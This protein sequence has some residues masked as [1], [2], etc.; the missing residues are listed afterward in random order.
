MEDGMHVSQNSLRVY[1]IKENIHHRGRSV[2]FGQWKVIS[3]AVNSFCSVQFR[4]DRKSDCPPARLP[5]RPLAAVVVQ[6]ARNDAFL[7]PFNGTPNHFR[8]L[9]TIQKKV[10]V[11]PVQGN[12]PFKNLVYCLRDWDWGCGRRV[13]GGV[14]GCEGRGVKITQK[15]YGV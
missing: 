4:N 8:F 11:D 13:G 1:N 7:L 15:N 2:R 6:T 12:K 14:G 9:P 5:V 10:S 3:T